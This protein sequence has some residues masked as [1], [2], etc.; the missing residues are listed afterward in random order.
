MNYTIIY[1]WVQH[2]ALALDKRCRA[3]LK[4][5][6]RMHHHVEKLDY[7]VDLTE[8]NV[9]DPNLGGI[10]EEVYTCLNLNCKNVEVRTA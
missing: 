2:C 8:L 10:F 5:I 7:R 6:N 9:V 4:P 1:R 3:N